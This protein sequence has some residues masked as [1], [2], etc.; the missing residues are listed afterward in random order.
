MD[1]I[2]LLSKTENTIEYI[3]RNLTEDDIKDILEDYINIKMYTA[4]KI[5]KYHKS[6]KGKK[7]TCD[8]SKRYYYKIKCNNRYH[9]IYNPLGE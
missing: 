3:Y 9:E 5:K 7:S 8:A 4:R 2:K 1:K 6:D